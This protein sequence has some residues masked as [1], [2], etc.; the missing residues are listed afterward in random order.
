MGGLRPEPI[1]KNP[2]C[3]CSHQLGLQYGPVSNLQHKRTKEGERRTKGSE[4]CCRRYRRTPEPHH[5]HTA[6]F[7]GVARWLPSAPLTLWFHSLTLSSTHTESSVTELRK[8]FCLHCHC[9]TLETDN[10]TDI[11]S[12]SY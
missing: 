12:Q 4:A 9:C 2:K 1:G 6:P 3:L 8:R 11:S 5:Q 10:Y 7:A